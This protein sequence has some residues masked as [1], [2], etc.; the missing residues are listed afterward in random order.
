MKIERLKF[1]I[2]L[3][4]FLALMNYPAYVVKG[5][6]EKPSPKATP[7]AQPTKEMGKGKGK[8]GK[9]PI[10]SPEQ[11]EKIKLIRDK[12]ED[13]TGDVQFD[14][15]KKRFELAD[16]LQKAEPDRKKIDAKINEML[17]MERKHYKLIIDEY[18]EIKKVLT[19][20]QS[21][22]FLRRF[23]RSMMKERGGNKQVN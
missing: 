10:L 3:A 17:G 12:F 16:E 9:F 4:V 5:Q 22:I 2:F 14:L 1:A 21:Q 20:Q 8:F 11:K 15:K 19:P 18:F 13:L 7:S 6:E 23:V